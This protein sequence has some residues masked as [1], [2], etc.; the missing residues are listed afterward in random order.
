MINLVVY[1]DK[2]NNAKDLVA[3]LLE[4]GLIANASIDHDNI[5]YLKKEG[6][7]QKTVNSVITAQTKAILFS[8]VT[9][10][11]RLHYGEHVPVYSLPITQANHS[12]DDLI[13]ENTKK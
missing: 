2:I 10:F 12:F 13:R 6:K 9:E 1:L 4:E 8:E 7:I 3:L 5:Y 11:I